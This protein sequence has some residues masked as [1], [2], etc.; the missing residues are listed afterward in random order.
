MTSIH[1][2]CARCGSKSSEFEQIETLSIRRCIKCG[3]VVFK[4][5]ENEKV[6]R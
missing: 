1:L 2:I 3:G 4:E 5:V 6:R